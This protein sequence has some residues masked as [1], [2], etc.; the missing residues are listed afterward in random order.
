MDSAP[1]PVLS[2]YHLGEKNQGS[3][4]SLFFLFFLFLFRAVPLSSQSRS[5]I[6]AAAPAYSTGTA[7]PDLSCLC[8]LPH[9]LWQCQILNPLIEAR[10]RTRIFMDTS[11]F[12]NLLSHNGNSQIIS[13]SCCMNICSKLSSLK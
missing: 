8:D 2:V 11:Q 6:A 3:Q 10:A 13:F 1:C 4:V 5:R 12:L 9:S 7:T